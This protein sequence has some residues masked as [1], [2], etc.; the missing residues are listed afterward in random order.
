[1]NKKIIMLAGAW[2]FKNGSKSINLSDINR[3]LSYSDELE[4]EKI[5]Y[6]FIIKIPNKEQIQNLN[7]KNGKIFYVSSYWQQFKEILKQVRDSSKLD[8]SITTSRLY[9]EAIFLVLISFFYRFKIV[10]QVHG[11]NLFFSGTQLKS[12]LK[13]LLFHFA[14]K[15]CNKIRIVNASMENKIKA[16][17]RNCSIFIAP[18]P[19]DKKIYK[20]I[21]KRKQSTDTGILRIGVI[22]RL[23]QEKKTMETL[24]W[25]HKWVTTEYTKNFFIEVCIV[26]DGPL[27]KE[28]ENLLKQKK[29][30]NFKFLGHLNSDQYFKI[31]S[32]LDINISFSNSEGYGRT[33]LECGVLGIPTIA[34][35]RS[36]D[37]K[38]LSKACIHRLDLDS[39][40]SFSS[41]SEIIETYKN[42]N[43]LRTSIM[44]DSIKILNSIQD[45][46]LKRI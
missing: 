40:S 15:N 41:F 33:V 9:D 23:S 44:N 45:C 35:F 37:D 2:H 32:S 43:E 25:L 1:M 27:Q 28:V 46:W 16:I 22:G 18:V 3:Y 11:F 36:L 29:Y 42:N 31:I 8:I 17:N 14:V 38:N 12:N 6:A 10:G 26:G 21:K 5:P 30:G 13:S 20:F 39:K 19:P 34:P 4:N 7:K 24:R